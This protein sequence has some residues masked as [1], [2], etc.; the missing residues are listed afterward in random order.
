MCADLSRDFKNFIWV[1][2]GGFADRWRASDAQNRRCSFDQDLKRCQELTSLALRHGARIDEC[3]DPYCSYANILFSIGS[4]SSL[5]PH[6]WNQVLQYL[7]QIGVT[8]ED[9]NQEGQTPLLAF[10]D[11]AADASVISAFL[12][13]G[14]DLHAKD[15]I[16]RGYLHLALSALL[17]NPVFLKHQPN[18]M[19]LLR[20][21]TRFNG[22]PITPK[23]TPL[24]LSL[25]LSERAWGVWMSVFEEMEWDK[26]AMES[27]RYTALCRKRELSLLERLP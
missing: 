8:M 23:E 20:A 9:R 3:V 18:I 16:G 15:K 21:D 5:L 13:A 17:R 26:E 4:A 12:A 10:V 24:I 2:W 19:T 14:A 27:Y 7:L 25:T 6:Q 1:T 11:F 22:R